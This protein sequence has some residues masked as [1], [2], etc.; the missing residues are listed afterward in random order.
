MIRYYWIV[1]GFVVKCSGQLWWSR[2]GPGCCTASCCV[3]T[4]LSILSSR[5]QVP[6]FDGKVWHFDFKCLNPL[7]VSHGLAWYTWAGP[8]SM[9][10]KLLGRELEPPYTSGPWRPVGKWV[11][12]EC[13]WYVLIFCVEDFVDSWTYDMSKQTDKQMI[14]GKNRNL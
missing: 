7:E 6:C 8:S 9:F 14:S 10:D 11:Q 4:C 13:Y 3:R 12:H 1:F 5:F 2:L